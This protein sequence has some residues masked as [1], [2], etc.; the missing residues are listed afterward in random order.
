MPLLNRAVS[1]HWRLF[2][3]YA[4]SAFKSR[5]DLDRAVR[6]FRIF[7]KVLTTD[8][9]RQ[10]YLY[11]ILNKWHD[12]IVSARI[13]N[14]KYWQRIDESIKYQQNLENNETEEIETFVTVQRASGY[15]A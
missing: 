1:S 5:D 2:L 3:L 6:N 4:K 15:R 11:F 12:K 8:I 13:Y 9:A 14:E 10:R 7:F